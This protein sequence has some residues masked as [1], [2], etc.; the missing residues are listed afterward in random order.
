[1]MNTKVRTQ[2]KE[3]TARNQRAQLVR[4]RELITTPCIKKLHHFWKKFCCNSPSAHTVQ[5]H[6]CGKQ[7]IAGRQTVRWVFCQTITKHCQ[8]TNNILQ[9]T[10]KKYCQISAI[11]FSLNNLIQQRTQYYLYY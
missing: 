1:M 10:L 3:C 2:T 6:Q 4:F 5:Q 7:A 8:I 9:R 11:F